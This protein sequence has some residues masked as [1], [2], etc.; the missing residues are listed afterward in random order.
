[1][2]VIYRDLSGVPLKH[3]SSYVPVSSQR[4][5]VYSY[6]RIQYSADVSQVAEYR[7]EA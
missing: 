2:T 5:T 3:T 1:M 7:S 4:Q 6:L